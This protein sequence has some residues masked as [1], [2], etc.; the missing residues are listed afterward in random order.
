MASHVKQ[1]P[2]PQMQPAGR[3][4][5]V[6]PAGAGLLKAKSVE[7]LILCGRRDDRLQ[8]ICISLGSNSRPMVLFERVIL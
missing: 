1:R 6:L 2:N 3:S 7:A 8:L 4:G 5:L